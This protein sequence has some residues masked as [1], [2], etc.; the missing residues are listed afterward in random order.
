VAFSS[1]GA[2]AYVTNGGSDSVS[3]IHVPSATLDF[4]ISVGVNPFGV[5]VSPDGSRVYVT[6]TDSGTVSVLSSPETG[7]GSPSALTATAAD[8]AVALSW[9]APSS[10]GGSTVTDYI[11]QYKASASSAWGTFI[12]GV[13]TATSA[14]VTGLTN[15]TAYDFRVSAVNSVGTGAA[16]VAAVATPV[17]GVAAPAA[18][19][20]AGKRLAE[21]GSE[22]GSMW[23]LA[24]LLLAAGAALTIRSRWVA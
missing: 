13:S 24:G 1:D 8:A 16:S 21:S 9:T 15:G 23:L 4:Q 5:A 6:N 18:V 14:R 10:D 19:V 7:P 2:F 22:G 17:A 20:E 11:V 3:V 12:D